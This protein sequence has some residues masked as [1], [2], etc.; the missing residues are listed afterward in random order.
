[1]KPSAFDFVRAGSVA[2]AVRLL[3]EANGA[4]RL[5]A[6]AQSLGPMLNLRLAQPRIL[7]D[8]TGI[9]DLMRIEEADDAVIVGACVTTANIE[10]GRLPGRG[11]DALPGFA[12]N[13]AYRAVRN[14]GTIGGSLCHADPAADWVSMLCALDAECLITGVNGKRRL[15]ADQ[16][17]RSA[18]ETALGPDEML[19]ALRIPRLSERGRCGYYKICRKPG[20]FAMAIGAVL[21]DPERRQSRMVIGAGRGRP[22]VVADASE[23]QGM[24]KIIDSGAVMRVLNTS[25]IVD[26]V[27]RSQKMA[28]LMRAYAMAMTL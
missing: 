23:L 25:G 26:R 9:P 21:H 6:G 24:D 7:I 13:I 27:E 22:I 4:A 8:I 18:Y 15:P 14:R 16:F 20:E 10:D 1:M 17:V 5:V 2:E 12:A 19:E 3:V 28:A 11:L